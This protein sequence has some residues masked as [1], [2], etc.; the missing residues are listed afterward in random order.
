MKR[1]VTALLACCFIASMSYAEE[2][3]V[4]GIELSKTATSAEKVCDAECCSK[5]CPI[6][7]AMAKLPKM[8][9]LVGKEETCCSCLLYT[10]PS[11]RDATL[12][13][14]PSSA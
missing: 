2:L 9:Y 13:R 6:E 1:I 10:S 4:V 8:T 7:A 14:M 11:P 12:S 5:G 3:K